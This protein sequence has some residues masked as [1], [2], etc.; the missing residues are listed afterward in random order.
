MCI[1]TN[2]NRGKAIKKGSLCGKK[3]VRPRR[4]FFLAPDKREIRNHPSSHSINRSLARQ[5]LVIW[6]LKREKWV[7]GWMD[8]AR[9]RF[10]INICLFALVLSIG[11]AFGLFTL[12]KSIRTER[13]R[14]WDEMEKLSPHH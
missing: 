14:L 7:D 1:K 12:L 9:P 5:V 13:R 8:A 4:F 2:I 6:N 11:N 3:R 10:S